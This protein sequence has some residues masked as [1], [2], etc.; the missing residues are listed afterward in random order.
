M[1]GDRGGQAA[2]SGHRNEVRL[3][4]QLSAGAEERAL[5]SGDAVALFRLTV[6]RA[7]DD[8]VG[9]PH[10]VRGPA[11]DTLQ[12]AVWRADIRPVVLSWPPGAVV[13]VRG[14]LR[15]RFW[16]SPSGP[17]SRYEVDVAAARRLDAVGPFDAAPE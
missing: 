17:A 14:A 2:D 3:V 15:R 9:R 1:S 6:R 11:S 16:R 10:R 5:P 13:E 8:A 7:A 4:G 12:C